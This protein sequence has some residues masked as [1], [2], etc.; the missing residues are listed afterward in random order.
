MR[1]CGPA[2]R[3]AGI[4]VVAFDQI[5]HGASPG[6]RTTSPQFTDVPVSVG[7]P[8]GPAHA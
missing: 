2:L 3:E 1:R 8:F 4:A 6:E 7:T 5:T